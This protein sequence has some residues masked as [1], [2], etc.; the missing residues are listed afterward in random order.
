MT[1]KELN[2]Q[3]EAIAHLRSMSYS[4]QPFKLDAKKNTLKAP[5]IAFSC[6]DRRDFF[7]DGI[8]YKL[9]SSVEIDLIISEKD[10]E[11]EGEIEQLLENA[12]ITYSKSE[13]YGASDDVYTIS[14]YT[15][16]LLDE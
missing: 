8:N 4:Y 9:I 7:A 11:L 3:V 13:T 16:V 12:E 5:Y 14:Y 10:P 15:E 1:L 2:T 6:P